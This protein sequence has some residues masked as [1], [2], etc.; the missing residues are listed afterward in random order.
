MVPQKRP[1]SNTGSSPLPSKALPKVA[2]RHSFGTGDELFVDVPPLTPSANKITATANN[3]SATENGPIVEETSQT[4]GEAS[5]ASRQ[6]H[7]HE[8]YPEASDGTSHGH[9]ETNESGLVNEHLALAGPV[10]AHHAS[11]GEEKGGATDQPI[12]TGRDE[13][14]DEQRGDED[15]RAREEPVA[16]MRDTPAPS[17]D[18]DDLLDVKI[19]EEDT[20][21]DDVVFICEKVAEPETI[22]RHRRVTKQQ[23]HLQNEAATATREGQGRIADKHNRGQSHHGDNDDGWGNAEKAVSNDGWGIAEKAVSNG[24]YGDLLSDKAEDAPGPANQTSWF[25]QPLPSGNVQYK[26]RGGWGGGGHRGQRG[27]GRGRGR[28]GGRG[29]GRGKARGNARKSPSNL[30]GDQRVVYPYQQPL[31]RD[32]WGVG[33]PSNV[34][35]VTAPFNIDHNTAIASS[36]KA[37]ANVQRPRPFGM[38]PGRDPESWRI[39]DLAKAFT[40]S[41]QVQILR[42]ATAEKVRITAIGPAKNESEN[43][44]SHPAT[45]RTGRP[46]GSGRLPPGASAMAHARN[47]FISVINNPSSGPPVVAT[48][49]TR[50][51]VGRLAE[52]AFRDGGI[53]VPPGMSTLNRIT[54]SQAIRAAFDELNKHDPLYRACP[55]PAIIEVAARTQ[56]LHHTRHL[57]GSAKPAQ[58]YDGI[59]KT[60]IAH[61]WQFA[62][63]HNVVACVP[64]GLAIPHPVVLAYAFSMLYPF[65][66]RDKAMRRMLYR[67]SMIGKIVET[68]QDTLGHAPDFTSARL[69]REIRLAYQDIPDN[70][71]FGSA[72]HTRPFGLAETDVQFRREVYLILSRQELRCA[73]PKPEDAKLQGQYRRMHSSHASISKA[74]WY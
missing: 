10:E 38:D 24:G 61:G 65:S 47:V 59:A 6:S 7:P 3:T 36:S 17:S 69:N 22:A 29:G 60:A 19:K 48:N 44:R 57:L 74:L 41:E 35:D 18:V 4:L 71:F 34:A 37:P 49:Y 52:A 40:I 32:T 72:E 33:L 51:E 9:A 67:I 31:E 42:E 8:R 23:K 5:S 64:N 70:I 58:D 11:Q 21:S 54:Q 30:F 16:R 63:M 28:G 68:V 73:L 26:A 20:S 50:D 53:K 1:L 39:Q 14:H 2:R 55:S 13:D 62:L 45:W 15:G 12:A 56:P 25:E 46:A 66:E 27:R 43:L